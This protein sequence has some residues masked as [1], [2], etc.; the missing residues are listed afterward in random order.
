MRALA[1]PSSLGNLS[2]P[3]PNALLPP[4]PLARTHTHTTC[5]AVHV[6]RCRRVQKALTACEAANGK[7]DGDRCAGLRGQLALCLAEV[8]CPERAAEYSQ[9]YHSVVNTGKYKAVA[10]CDKQEEGMRRC[11]RGFELP[12]F[13]P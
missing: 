11:L 12:G 1:A 7:A 3:L 6:R 5:P 4:T 9:C 13:V 10:D 8:A 2:R